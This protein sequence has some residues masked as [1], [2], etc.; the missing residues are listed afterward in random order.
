LYEWL[1]ENVVNGTARPAARRG[2]LPGRESR[3]PSERLRPAAGYRS[4]T[5][6]T[7]GAL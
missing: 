4:R 5:S 7:K 2:R 6:R 1:R 3:E